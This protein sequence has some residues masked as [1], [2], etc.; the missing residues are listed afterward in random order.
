MTE[1]NEWYRNG[2]GDL[3]YEVVRCGVDFAKVGIY[4][5]YADAAVKAG[6]IL[7]KA[8]RFHTWLGTSGYFGADAAWLRVALRH[9]RSLALAY[10]DTQR[11]IP[12]I[13][14]RGLRACV[15]PAVL[16][17]DHFKYPGQE[18]EAHRAPSV[19]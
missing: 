16:V 11:P 10:R 19:V 15:A 6:E 12:A 2:R 17:T 1:I 9:A 14:L 13:R 3:R 5:M 4:V 8:S 18:N 7:L